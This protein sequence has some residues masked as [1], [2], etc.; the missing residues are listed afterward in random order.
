MGVAIITGASS[1]LGRA[2]VKCIYNRYPDIDEMWLVA[3][4][5]ERLRELA[6]E[7][8]GR[9]VEILPLDLSERDTFD[10]L[11]A[12]LKARRPA[13]RLLVNCAGFGK[14]GDFDQMDAD[15]LMDMISLNCTGL[16]AVTRITAPYLQTDAAVINVCS[17]GAFVPMPNMVV[18]GATKSYVLAFSKALREEW[19]TR[20]VHVVAVCPGPMETEFF[21]VAGAKPFQKSALMPYDN[22]DKIAQRSLDCAFRR[23]AVYVGRYRYRM[24]RVFLKMVPHNWIIRFMRL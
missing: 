7:L 8:N 15:T 24:Y 17:V 2:Y 10:L 1:G 19:R 22:A 5:T 20:R 14:C 16:T 23:K 3:R 9:R 21:E 4:R 6:A 11:C 18:Y 12:L 13:I